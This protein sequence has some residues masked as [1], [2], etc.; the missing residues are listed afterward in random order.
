MTI[1][2]K[3]EGGY[4]E[5][6]GD[7]TVMEGNRLLFCLLSFPNTALQLVVNEIIE[8]YKLQID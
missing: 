4:E 8:N 2:M 5:N 7:A 1:M 6:R 3:D